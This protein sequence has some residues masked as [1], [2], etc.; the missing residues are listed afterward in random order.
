MTPT[1]AQKI[2]QWLV[3]EIEPQR[4]PGRIQIQ[5]VHK[6]MALAEES[7]IKWPTDKDI[8]HAVDVEW[9]SVPSPDN[10]GYVPD[11]GGFKCGF[12]SAV[13]WLKERMEKKCQS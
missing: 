5:F 6:V 9:K 4:I 12:W 8:F 7:Q 11:R 1:E 3:K 10:E 2:L 13:R